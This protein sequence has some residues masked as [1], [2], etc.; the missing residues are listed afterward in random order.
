MVSDTLG[1]DMLT[2]WRSILEQSDQARA[3]RLRFARDRDT[4]VAAH[5]LKQNLLSSAED[6]PPSA[7]RFI[8]ARVGKPQIDPALGRPRF[9][10]NLSHTSGLVACALNLDHEVGLDVE[11]RH[12]TRDGLD[13]D[14]RFLLRPS[15]CCWPLYRKI[16]AA[17]GA[18]AMIFSAPRK[19]SPMQLRRVRA[20]GACAALGVPGYLMTL[21]YRSTQCA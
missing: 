7:W 17:S 12:W 9:H 4:F 20:V 19:L 11:A 6:L 10:F 18:A 8:H 13:I 15:S 1:A 5:A 16:V 14:E 3:D 21:E 2:R